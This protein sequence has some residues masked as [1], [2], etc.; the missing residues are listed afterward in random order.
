M[1]SE[2]ERLFR[3]KLVRALIDRLAPHTAGDF[4]DNQTVLG[5][6]RETVLSNQPG[7]SQLESAFAQQILGKI[8]GY[9]GVGEGGRLDYRFK[10][11]TGT[12]RIPDITMGKE[13]LGKGWQ[14]CAIL[15]LKSP[16]LLFHKVL[17]NGK[18]PIEQAWDYANILGNIE[19][20]LLT[21]FRTIRLYSY[22]HGQKYAEDFD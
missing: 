15:E 19:W 20:V 1:Y 22:R 16:N 6:W 18:T 13:I 9:Q 2:T 11:N 17:S 3:P 14:P 8:L 21:N 5:R 4:H 10:E 12:G 7:E